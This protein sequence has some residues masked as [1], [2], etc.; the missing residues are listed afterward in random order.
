MMDV[1]IG[2]NIS[3]SGTSVINNI[4]NGTGST[5]G[6]SFGTAYANY[7]WLYPTFN[8]CAAMIGTNISVTFPSESWHSYQLQYKNDLTDPSWS[9]LGSPIGG[10]DVLQ[11]ILDSTSAT[12][13]FY[14]IGSF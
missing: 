11:T 6:P 10:N 14:R 8:I 2:G 4:I 9:N 12:N 7:L 3:G 5:V 13:R 1:Y